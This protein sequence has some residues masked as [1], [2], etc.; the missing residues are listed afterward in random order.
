[1]IPGHF[2]CSKGLALLAAIWLCLAFP[3][4]AS[5]HLVSSG[6]GPFFDG[7]AHFFVSVYDLLA[8]VALSLLSGL[9]GKPATRR[10]VFVLPG[11]W[12]VGTLL[13]YLVPWRFEE[14][15]W[16]GANSLLLGG[17]LLAIH[18]QLSPWIPVGLGIA[19]GLM[20]GVLNGAAISATDSTILTS[21]GIVAAA[22]VLGLLL[23]A[24]T[25]SRTAAWQRIALR[26]VGSWVAAIG[27]LSLAWQFRPTG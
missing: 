14:A 8:V 26:V 16:L 3:S 11:A 24:A 5:A 10:F 7:I 2:V 25:V 27:L 4:T 22:G 20:H 13:G 1:M 6:V 9:S 21:L 15:E 19:I 17:L 18:P 23:G 12:L